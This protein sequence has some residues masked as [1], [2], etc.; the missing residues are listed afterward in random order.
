VSAFDM[1]HDVRLTLGRSWVEH[2]ILG[3]QV[4]AV[5]DNSIWIELYTTTEGENSASPRIVRIDLYHRA[6]RA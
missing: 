6:D 1:E 2:H 4:V 3:G 5:E